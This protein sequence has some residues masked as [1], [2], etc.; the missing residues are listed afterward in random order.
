MV[1][2][3]FFINS[4]WFHSSF[5]ALFSSSH[6]MKKA[7]YTIICNQEAKICN[8][9]PF[10]PSVF[11]EAASIFWQEFSIHFFTC[12]IVELYVWSQN[13]A[14]YCANIILIIKNSSISNKN[15]LLLYLSTLIL[16]I[17]PICAFI[18]YLNTT[19]LHA[20]PVL[21]TCLQMCKYT[22]LLWFI[23]Y[24]IVHDSKILL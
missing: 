17:A 20:P 15:K 5:R 19:L 13:F 3:H 4:L 8:N 7:I 21:P 23:F 14:V 22:E 11:S 9:Q 2:D 6:V 18:T 24:T 1:R 12:F 10:V 16:S